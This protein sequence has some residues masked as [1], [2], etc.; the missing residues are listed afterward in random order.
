MKLVLRHHDFT[1]HWDAIQQTQNKTVKTTSA[2][3]PASAGFYA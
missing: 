3:H 2:P 1:G